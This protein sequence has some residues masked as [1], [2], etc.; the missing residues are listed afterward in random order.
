MSAAPLSFGWILQPEPLR[1]PAGRGPGD[2]Q[3]ART[4]ITTN[5]QYVA[6]AR[7]AGFDT[8]WVEDHFGWTDTPRLE[9]L[10]TLAWL[11]GRHPGLRYGT[12]VC[13]Q[14]FRNPAL[15]AKMAAN[16]FLLTEGRFILGIGAGNNPAEHQQYGYRWLPAGPRLAQLA[17][18]IQILRA[19]WAES[20]A[21][22]H[23]QY[24]FID[25]ASASPRPDA[26]MPLMIGGGGEKQTLRL[27]AQ[28]ADWW[29]NDVAS[30]EVFAH[31]ARV[32]REHCRAVGR[33]PAHLVL[34]QDVWISIA[35]D[36][37]RAERWD[38]LHIVAG[39]PD[40]VTRELA[41]FRAAGAQHFQIRFL[42]YPSTR[43]LEQ[44]AT[45]IMPR[46]I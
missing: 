44:F 22:V 10:T 16:L 9:C 14:A 7:S 42:D 20:P 32:L 45:T 38:P 28:Y 25:H 41:Q 31:K 19:L 35:D 17:E 1:L 37:A 6:L 23:G 18:A 27:V 5:E 26:P 15:L 2:S 12:M 46:L 4:L 8:I 34:A 40:A 43:G 33:D 36:A 24:Y 21:T 29:C 11:A 13:G 39:T 30:V 3:L